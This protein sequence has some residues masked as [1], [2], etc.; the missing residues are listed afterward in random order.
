MEHERAEKHKMLEE[1]ALKLKNKKAETE[2]IVTDNENRQAAAK[3]REDHALSE[4]ETAQENT[5][6]Q[7]SEMREIIF[8]GGDDRET[9]REESSEYIGEQLEAQINAEGSAKK[10]GDYADVEDERRDTEDE[11][12]AEV[13]RQR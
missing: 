10:A 7:K 3:T 9:M 6:S 8:D 4:T 13:K 2:G 11:N 1:F 5:E 12:R